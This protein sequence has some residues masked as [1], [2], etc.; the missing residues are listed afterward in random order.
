MKKTYEHIFY[1]I[2]QDALTSNQMNQNKRKTDYF[3]DGLEL[4]KR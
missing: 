1:N 4:F 2:N 3:A